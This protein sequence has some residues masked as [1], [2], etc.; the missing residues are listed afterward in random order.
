MAAFNEYS[1]K[2]NKSKKI[3]KS[4]LCGNSTKDTYVCEF[5][6][7]FIQLTPQN[8]YWN[9]FKNRL[10]SLKKLGE[11]EEGKAR[12]HYKHDMVFC[13]RKIQEKLVHSPRYDSFTS[14]CMHACVCIFAIS[15]RVFFCLLIFHKNIYACLFLL[16]IFWI[17]LP[18]AYELNCH[19]NCILF[20]RR[21]KTN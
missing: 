1:I 17:F 5:Q 18:F 15:F 4:F 11:R 9:T 13:V 2:S 12:K 20:K 6:S 19:E 3:V 14:E 8:I 16:A 21:K 7:K 10:G